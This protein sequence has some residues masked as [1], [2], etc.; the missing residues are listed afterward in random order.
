MKKIIYTLCAL[1]ILLAISATTLLAQPR[2]YEG[3]NDPAGDRAALR[4][5]YMEGN[6]VRLQFRNTTELSDWGTGTD[7]F[8]SKWPNTNLG[9]KMSDGVGLMIAARVYLQQDTIPV[10]NVDVIQNWNEAR[11]G[12][13]DTLYFLETHY[14]E[15]MDHSETGDILYGFYPVFGYFNENGL[16]ETPAISD[17]PDSWPP[18]G[19]P[20]KGGLQYG[21]ALDGSKFFH[22]RFGIGTEEKPSKAD[23]E[24]YFVAND[25]QDQEYFEDDLPTAY[26]PR[27][28]G[29]NN[30][31][32]I[33]DI[34]P[35]V[36]IGKGKPWGGIGIRVEQR[37]Y[38]WSNP[39]SQDAIFWEYNI[40]NI[41]EYNLT[42]VAF[43][44]WVD[45]GVGDDGTDE[46]GAFD[47]RIDLAYSWD[48]NGVGLGGRRT[49]TMGFAFLE[50]PGIFDD[51]IDNDDDGL[52]DERRDKPLA[53]A[54][55]AGEWV[56]PEYHI[57]D[58]AKFLSFYNL[59]QEELEWHWEGDEDQ[60]WRAFN[61][62]NGNKVWDEGEDPGDDVGIDGFGPGELGYEK[63]GPD[64]GE[65]DGK[66]SHVPGK[67]C[68]PNFNA[69]DISESDMLGLTAFQ[70]YP[71]NG[72]TKLESSG[73]DGSGYQWFYGDQSMFTIMA[74]DSLQ[75]YK[76]E[77][78]NLVE[79]FAS[80]TF[81]LEQG[82]T[83]RISMSELHSYD[84]LE[85]LNGESHS[86]PALFKL[87]EIV[88]IIYERD[89]RFAQAPVTPS[90]T[91]T[92]GDGFVVL[93][94]DHASDQLTREAFLDNENDFEGYM[95]FKTTDKLLSEAMTITDGR[96]NPILRAPIFQCD[97]KNGIKDF[98]TYGLTGGQ[99]FYLGDDTGLQHFFVDSTVKNG[100]TYYYGLIAYDYGVPPERLSKDPTADKYEKRTGI[101]PSFN[102]LLPELDANENIKY[103]PKNMAIV[104]PGFQPAGA[105]FNDSTVTNHELTQM[106]GHGV[107]TPQVLL[108]HS[109]VENATYLVEFNVNI[110]RVKYR[111]YWSHG[112]KYT[113]DGLRV[114]RLVDGNKILVYEDVLMLNETDVEVPKNYA[115]VLMDSRQIEEI[116]NWHISTMGAYTGLFEGM[117][118]Y[119][120]MDV[121]LPTLDRINTGWFPA[122]SPDI[123]LRIILAP[124]EFD[125]FGWDYNIR[126]LT[127]DEPRYTTQVRSG[128]IRD[129]LYQRV[130]KGQ[131]LDNIEFPFII[132]NQNFVDSTRFTVSGSDTIYLPEIMD[133]I[134]IDMN[135]NGTFE[136]IEDKLLVGAITS[137]EKRWSGSIFAMDFSECSPEALPKPNDVYHVRFKRPFYR[138]DQYAFKI[139]VDKEVTAE[140]VKRDME[141]IKVVPNPYVATNLMEPAL[142]N[143][144]LNQRRRLMFTHIPERCTIKIFTVSG[145]FVDEI[146]APEDGLVT[147]GGL[148]QTTTGIIHWDLKTHE[149]LD[150]AAGIYI[151]HV[152]DEETGEEKIGKFAVIK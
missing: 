62:A 44:Y 2:P 131:I 93:T 108:P 149:G 73:G 125:Y 129:E 22:G 47:K 28:Y 60:D 78:S 31:I 100:V 121:A 42:E 74:E 54:D 12:R 92:P 114:Y 52:I 123:P 135:N 14:R 150:V 48:I 147:W 13:L 110:I 94:W 118:L 96:G 124:D 120:K 56:A 59:K 95:L 116:N 137:T 88:Q 138:S 148:G 117:R 86:A 40:A 115:T 63:V 140:E 17:D 127:E 36:T 104:T 25:A 76:G 139:N 136:L 34:R 15:E 146:R 122:K 132:E 80:G 8:A 32:R 109:L 71:I 35:D 51:G 65:C 30:P 9:L 90:L 29:P 6:R 130:D 41:S 49:G 107:I 151:F 19:W 81:K 33:G 82:Q 75:E 61:D 38:Q 37:G 144:D 69:M 66:P 58:M 67:G 98:A 70:M 102:T 101:A 18:D 1:F 152:K 84:P 106:K 145:V 68:E 7:P 3:P 53:W 91:A 89:Y 119:V 10:D 4:R 113:A 20:A 45:N 133:V 85:G 87:K 79:V 105:T 97:L 72:A 39:E 142:E 24:C 99:G 77:I 50:S 43:G 11:D 143:P 21:P 26:Y 83:E 5:G 57:T 23:L 134:A 16:E 55:P 126:W 112:V 103:T 27:L 111:K 128:T 64:E 141:K 46:R